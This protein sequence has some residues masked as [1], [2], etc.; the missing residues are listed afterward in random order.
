M[1]VAV[2][3]VAAV[4]STG[5]PTSRFVAAG[6][7]PS[8]VTTSTSVSVST[9][10]VPTTTLVPSTTVRSTTATTTRDE[11]PEPPTTVPSCR[12]NFD[13]PNC[14]A[15]YW[16]PAPANKPLVGA[17]TL[18]STYPVV[19]TAYTLTI[20]IADPDA[21]LVTVCGGLAATMV[22]NQ[23]VDY[24]GG[25]AFAAADSPACTTLFGGYGPHDPPLPDAGANTTQTS[26]VTFEAAGDY[27]LVFGVTSLSGTC[28]GPY[29]DTTTLT[30]DVHVT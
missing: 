28:G 27:H 14:G 22:V 30:L 19:G 23:F 24:P 6:T 7:S 5:S 26:S 3:A 9:S 17:V 12:N 15:W 2:A 1:I 4:A 8:Q 20:V 21:R 25:C 16:D 10:E 18:S 29:D 13:N 11:D